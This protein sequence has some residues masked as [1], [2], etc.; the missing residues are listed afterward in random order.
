M[1]MAAAIG[2]LCRSQRSMMFCPKR[3]SSVVAANA[4]AINEERCENLYP[5]IKPKYP[6]G[7]WGS[8]D[9]GYAWLWHQWREESMAIEDPR[10]RIAALCEKEMTQLKYSAKFYRPRLL[11]YHQYITKTHL[12]SGLPQ[13]YSKLLVP[14]TID[15]LTASLTSVICDI[16]VIETELLERRRYLA[17]FPSYLH[18]MKISQFLVRSILQTLITR[19]GEHFPHLRTIQID[20]DAR[21]QAF[22]DRHGIKRMRRRFHPRIYQWCPVYDRRITSSTI[23]DFVL[24]AT[25]PLPEVYNAFSFNALLCTTFTSYIR[26]I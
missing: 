24:R 1:K 8:M 6:P 9:P 25:K 4:A 12:I 16:I 22:W 18:S 20:E 17:Q 26:R 7:R 5:P 2:R 14:E 13:L 23:A 3:C 15:S 11:P 19:L 21:I 10:E